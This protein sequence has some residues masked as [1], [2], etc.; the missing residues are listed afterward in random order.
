LLLKLE[1]IVVN[2]DLVNNFLV[3]LELLCKLWLENRNVDFFELFNNVFT[4]V[5]QVTRAFVGVLVSKCLI[6]HLLLVDLG[7]LVVIK[8]EPDLLHSVEHVRVVMSVLSEAVVTNDRVQVVW[9]LLVLNVWLLQVLLQIDDL[10]LSFLDHF[11]G[12][13]LVLLHDFNCLLDLHW[14]LEVV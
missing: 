5:K 1:R 6:E 12:E 11:I 9:L 13:V 4:D 2:F 3:C 8:F 7:D 14:L 10:D